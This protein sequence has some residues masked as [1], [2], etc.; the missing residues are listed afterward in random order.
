MT[1][2]PQGSAFAIKAWAPA[3]L[4]AEGLSSD[5]RAAFPPQAARS[6]TRFGCL[7]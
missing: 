3:L 5:I 1:P 6:R 7:H 2:E 4:G